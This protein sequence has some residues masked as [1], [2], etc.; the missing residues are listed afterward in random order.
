MKNKSLLYI[1]LVIWVLITLLR[2]AYHQPWYDEAHAYML[3]QNLTIP[4]LI[5][6]MKYEGHLLVWYLLIMPFAKL[7]LWYPY[8]MQILNWFSAFIALLVMW[9]KAP[10]HPV[11]KTIITFSYPFIAEM[12][13]IARCYSVGIMLLIIIA[14]LYHKSLKHPIW[15]A[16][17][18]LLCANTSVMA[19]FGAAAFGI[20]FAY[21]LIRAALKDEVTRKNFRIAFSI[22]A[23]CAVL[24]LWQIGGAATYSVMQ[25]GTFWENFASF[26]YGWYVNHQLVYIKYLFWGILGL[27]GAFTLPLLF[28]RNRKLLFILVFIFSCLL[29][30]FIFRYPGFSQ[31]YI[32]FWIYLLMIY[33]LLIEKEGRGTKLMVFAE[34]IFVLFFGIQLMSKE[35]EM[36]KALYM[37]KAHSMYS[38]ILSYVPNSNSRIILTG[39]AYERVV[40]YFDNVNIE[41]YS[42]SKAAPVNNCVLLEDTPVYQQLEQDMFI[43]TPSWLKL[44][45]SSDKNNYVIIPNNSE[46]GSGIIKD[47]R[48]RYGL[49]FVGTLVYDAVLYKVVEIDDYEQK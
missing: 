49:D 29:Y 9:K 2:V 12:P 27:T 48:K 24:V 34:V 11:T 35:T 18:I 3:A 46:E 4:E 5:A 45:V 32:F 41:I 22:L 16:V 28:L 25:H 37:S 38:K 42:Y 26:I 47:N 8:P 33:W 14:S 17:L 23:L 43:P 31:H 36:S 19:L 21:D 13:V 30:C 15:Y 7:K 20:V 10:F 44:S 40:P 1:C 6:E 39:T